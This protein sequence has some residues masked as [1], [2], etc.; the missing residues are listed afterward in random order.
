MAVV[1]LPDMILF[2]YK[3]RPAFVSIGGLPEGVYGNARG[4]FIRMASGYSFGQI[5]HELTH[6]RQFYR[7]FGLHDLLCILFKSYKL[8]TEFEAYRAQLKMDGGTVT[9]MAAQ[10]VA[11]AGF[12]ITQAE[13]E[14]RLWG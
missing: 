14:R 12:G 2:V 5:E 9:D 8:A 6:V 10:I 7:T 11:N 4:M 13:A 3:F 1:K